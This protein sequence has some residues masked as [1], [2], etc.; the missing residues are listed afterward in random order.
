MSDLELGNIPKELFDKV[1]SALDYNVKAM[2][3]DVIL[4]SVGQS[5]HYLHEIYFNLSVNGEITEYYYN[6]MRAIELDENES[7]DEFHLIYYD[8]SSII[9]YMNNFLTMTDSFLVLL[10]NQYDE[11]IDLFKTIIGL[12][13]KT[14]KP[15]TLDDMIDSMYYDGDNYFLR[16][17]VG[18]DNYNNKVMIVADPMLNIENKTF[19]FKFRYFIGNEQYGTF[20][21]MKAGFINKHMTPP[22]GESQEYFWKLNKK[23]SK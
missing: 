21:E 10:G 15:K 3:K 13:I 1:S 14:I 7:P 19:F 11:L 18:D 8:S 4:Q 16:A 23:E 9:N 5:N 12:E 2:G 6:L 20:E 17:I 22:E